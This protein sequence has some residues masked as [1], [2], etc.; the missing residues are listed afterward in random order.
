MADAIVERVI[1]GTSPPALFAEHLARYRFAAKYVAGG[2]VLDIACGSGYGTALLR[3]AGAREVVGVDVDPEAIAY[4]RSRYEG[5]G[6]T[7]LAGDA[8]S[9]PVEGLFDLIVS[10]ETIEHLR[11]PVRFCRACR[12]R[13]QP[14]GLF[15]VSTPWRTGPPGQRP[16]NPFH[17][18]EWRPDE[19]RTLLE[20]FFRDVELHGQSVALVKRPLQLSRRLARPLARLRGFELND[21]EHIFPLPGPRFPGLW[22]AYPATILAICR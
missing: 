13:L 11:D 22:T 21:P 15:I 7:F 12:E 20:P 17:V 2:R 18:R 19:F 3:E 9:P 5:K 14:G 16:K 10:F 4:A 6:V 1:E 8:T